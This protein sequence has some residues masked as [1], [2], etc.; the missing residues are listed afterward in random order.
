MN[1]TEQGAYTV[2][3]RSLMLPMLHLCNTNNIMTLLQYKIFIFN[4]SFYE[5]KL[6]L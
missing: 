6:F 5:C 1:M 2:Q 3:K 4:L